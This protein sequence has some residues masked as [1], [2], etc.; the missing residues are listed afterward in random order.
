MKP[1]PFYKCLAHENDPL[2]EHLLRVA[3]EAVSSVSEADGELV[4]VAFLAGLLHDIGKA[5]YYFQQDRLV[6][7]RKNSKTTHS[8]CSACVSWIITDILNLPLW[9]RLSVFISIL[10]H[11]GNLTFDC[12]ESVFANVRSRIKSDE[13]LKLQIESLDSQNIMHWLAI[14]ISDHFSHISQTIIGNLKAN[15]LTVSSMQ[16]NF[17]SVRMSQIR[18]SFMSLSEIF[19]FLAGFGAILSA[20]KIDSAIKTSIKRKKLPS[21]LVKEYKACKFGNPLTAMNEIREQ[22]FEETETQWNRNAGHRLFTLTA[23]TGSGKTLTIFNA[24]LNARSILGKIRKTP[25]RIIYCLP[26]TSVIDQNHQVITELLRKK[27][28]GDREDLLLK[29]HHLVQG[30]FRSEDIRYDSDDAGELLTETWQSE[31]VVTT[32]YQ[33]LHSLI[34]YRNA[35][36]KRAGQLCGSIV[37]MDEVQAVPLRYWKIIR[38]VFGEAAK[39]LNMIFVLLTATRPLIFR[40]DDPEIRELLPGH[41]SYF[42][43]LSRVQLTCYLKPYGL[44]TFCEKIIDDLKKEFKSTLIILNRR[45]SVKQ[46][47]DE[48]KNVYPGYRIIALSTNLTPWDRRARIRLVQQ[49]LKR[50]IQCVVIST[51]LVEAGVDLSF[52]VV[53]REIAPLDSIIQSCGRSNRNSSDGTGKVFVWKL[54]GQ[55]E[56]G[57]LGNPLWTKIYDAPLIQATID[58]LGI[59][60]ESQI[61]ADA[62][63]YQEK[64]FLELSQSYFNRCW[65]RIDQVDLEKYWIKGEFISLDKQFKLIEKGPPTQTCFVIQDDIDQ[66]IWNQYQSIFLED[67]EPLEKKKRFRKIRRKFYERVIQVYAP[68]DP[69]RDPVVML[70]SKQYYSKCIGFIKIPEKEPL[71]I[72]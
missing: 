35:E 18:K 56:K 25:P 41:P 34:S 12:W 50:N 9:I 39:T 52:P 23:P 3:H 13:T 47:Y 11:H 72:F 46:V 2:P 33:L 53:H 27:S 36:L 42:A 71:C 61:Y 70:N 37:L 14:R 7:K 69:S 55:S 8:E 17:R 58:I 1:F 26:F 24:A 16:E 65:D 57:E 5:T 31:I 40:H 63:E 48:L 59:S 21:N 4:Q 64:D 62:V 28:L 54:H 51:Q 68:K 45:S 60:S 22:I 10:K 20:D 43:A 6:K 29:H 32:F 49:Y 67:H 30:D 66:E 15:R 19:T 44:K 38:R